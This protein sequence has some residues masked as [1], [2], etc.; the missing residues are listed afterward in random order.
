MPFDLGDGYEFSLLPAVRC[1]RRLALTISRPP[2]LVRCQQ[3]F[4]DGN[5]REV[6]LEFPVE[7]M[8]N[9]SVPS[10]TREGEVGVSCS[11]DHSHD[12]VLH[13]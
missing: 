10:C 1:V 6:S 3:L 7:A 2:S 8:G 11:L 13:C 9:L 12:S 5:G 4:C